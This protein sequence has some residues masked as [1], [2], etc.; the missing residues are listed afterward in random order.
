M[1][2]SGLILSTVSLVFQVFSGCV[3]GY[4]LFSEARGLEVNHQFLRI[5]FKTEQY[6]LLDWADIAG[7]TEDDSTLV[8]SQAMKPHL[9]DIL[10]QQY[11]L[12]LRFGRVD[13]RLR[14]LVKP[15]IQEESDGSDGRHYDEDRLAD[16]FPTTRPLYL[17]ALKYIQATT[18]HPVRIRWAISDKAKVEDI[19]L[20]LTALNDS[21][22]QLFTSQQLQTLEENVIRT[23]YQI[24]QMNQ[25]FEHLCQLIEAGL[26]LGATTTQT[27]PMSSRSTDGGLASLARFKGFKSAVDG[28]VLDE[29]MRA[30][31]RLDRS[32]SQP[33]P[34]KLSSADIQ[35]I[36]EKAY[37]E[38]QRAPAWYRCSLA[39]WRRV[40]IEWT[41]TKFPQTVA[42]MNSE[43]LA[44][45]RFE[46]LVCLLRENELTAQFH[47]LKCHGYY[48]RHSQFEKQY[49]LVFESPSDAD[50]ESDPISLFDLLNEE[51]VPSLD[52]R[53]T[54][55]R[56][57]TEAVEKLHAVDWLHK[58]L[59]SQ[60]ILFFA[61]SVDTVDFSAP[62]ISGFE[63]SRPDTDDYLSENPPAIAA[64]DLYRHPSV[65]GGLRD[66]GHGFGYKKQ[67]D[68]YSL[69]VLILEIAYW[70]PVYQILGYRSEQL[71]KPSETARVKE[72]LL[73]G[74]YGKNISAYMGD[75]VSDVW[76]AS[77]MG[78]DSFGVVE[79]D[80][81]ATMGARLQEKFFELFVK[82][83]QQLR[84]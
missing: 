17:K 20:K 21:L 30:Q 43:P 59:R 4:Q 27:Q 65:Q 18:K 11:R 36:D 13:E 72:K 41:S 63:Y 69:G 38:R 15:F 64:E 32:L 33:R 77:L 53:L 5:R 70:K 81:D 25:K 71:I 10:D 73:S 45:K 9:L 55:V 80:S 62:F 50:A 84:I 8:I 66:S 60:N 56:V 1:A 78:L 23:N 44:L 35:L 26:F 52:A 67:H 58:G 54:L 16:R 12:M 83:L 57:L 40:W 22:H 68:I 42:H 82:R 29:T 74:R 37:A 34:I 6:R 3:H 2:E 19:L 51:S 61:D 28:D 48:L 46:N 14:P 79:D 39:P 47:A 76:R 31:L 49:G 24:M 75:V 7:L